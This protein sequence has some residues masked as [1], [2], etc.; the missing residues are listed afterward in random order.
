MNAGGRHLAVFALLLSGGAAAEKDLTRWVD[1]LIGTSNTSA[2][3][4]EVCCASKWARCRGSTYIR[5]CVKIGVVSRVGIE[6]TA[7]GLK[8]LCSTPEL[9]AHLPLRILKISG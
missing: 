7:K 2:F 1:P 9:P 6:P 8:G 5:Q 3:S 4:V